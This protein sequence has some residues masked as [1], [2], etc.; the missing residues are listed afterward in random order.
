MPGR[1]ERFRVIPMLVVADTIGMDEMTVLSTRKGSRASKKKAWKSW[2]KGPGRII[3][4]ER[5]GI[6]EKQR[7]EVQRK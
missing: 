7:G 5:L 4:K 6:K 3:W 1:R 2:C